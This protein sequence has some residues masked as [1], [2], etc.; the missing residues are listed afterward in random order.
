[1]K[2]CFGNR[3]VEYIMTKT[4]VLKWTFTILRFFSAMSIV[5][6]IRDLTFEKTKNQSAIG[7]WVYKCLK[8]ST[9]PVASTGCILNVF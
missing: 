2:T 9:I 5:L 6:F 1:M 4:F 3:F 7:L 8:P